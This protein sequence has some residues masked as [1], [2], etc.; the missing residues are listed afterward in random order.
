[1]V[2][3]WLLASLCDVSLCA[4][5]AAVVCVY[6]VC[7][8]ALLSCCSCAIGRGNEMKWVVCETCAWSFKTTRICFSGHKRRNFL[9]WRLL[10][11]GSPL[12]MRVWW[13][14][15]CRATAF[16]SCLL[17]EPFIHS[18]TLFLFK[19]KKPFNIMS[20]AAEKEKAKLDANGVLKKALA[21]AGQGGLAGA[22]AMVRKEIIHDW[23][24]F[25]P[26]SVVV[27]F[28]FSFSD[29]FV[30]NGVVLCCPLGH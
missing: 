12:M 10:L 22:A 4:A 23:F 14:V 9:C 13:V 7:V 3:Y 18:F 1:M 26:Y 30:L 28:T 25:T 11:V 16:R 24:V 8:F 29:H 19:K 17:C 20:S 5:A 6:D 15:V 2:R 21:R 27:L